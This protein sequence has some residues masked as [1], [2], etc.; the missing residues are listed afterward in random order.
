MTP[1]S[2]PNCGAAVPRRALA[3]PQCGADENTGWNDRATGQR[4]DLPDD[5]FNYDEFV[6]EEFGEQRES[7]TKTKGVGWLWWTVAVGLV[8]AFGFTYFR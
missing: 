1:E 4:L 6:K 2:C 7:R 3:C 5:E 8:L